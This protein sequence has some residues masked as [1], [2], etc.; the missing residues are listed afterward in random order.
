MAQ[1]L[2][3]GADSLVPLVSRPTC[4]RFSYLSHR[5][6]GPRVRTVLTH[7]SSHNTDLWTHGIRPI[8]M[9]AGGGR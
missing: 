9:L 4:A 3:T 8:P 6:V 7:D 1:K 2:E 5:Q